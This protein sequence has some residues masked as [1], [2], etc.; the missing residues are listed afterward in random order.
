MLAAFSG[1]MVFNL[2]VFAHAVGP[3]TQ[4]LV[5]FAV[6]FGVRVCVGPSHL[7]LRLRA[8]D[9]HSLAS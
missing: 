9:T 3:H 5:A 7:T 2:G 8:Q 6:R 1:P 4:L